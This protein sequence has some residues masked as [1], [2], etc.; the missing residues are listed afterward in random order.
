MTFDRV[1]VC[2]IC[3]DYNLHQESVIAWQRAEAA[4]STRFELGAAAV[5]DADDNPSPRREAVEIRFWCE[6]DHRVR[7]I[8]AQHKGP[9]FA[10]WRERPDAPVSFHEY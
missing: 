7:L 9:T 1:L 5:E 6:G 8:L 2:P 10:W 4:P 3:G